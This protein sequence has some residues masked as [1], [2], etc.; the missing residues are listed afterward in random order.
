MSAGVSIPL[1]VG[2]SAVAALLLSG[3]T[4]IQALDARLV[5]HHHGMRMSLLG[6]LLGRKRWVLGTVIGYAA[7]PF[8]LIA[9]AHAPLVL[10]QPVHACGLLLLLFA[11][12][13]MFQERLHLLDLLGVAALAVGLV[14]VTWGSPRGHDPPRSEA[15]LAG[16]CAALLAA[17]IIP[18]LF[19]SRC[20]RLVLVLSAAI[21]FA[22]ANFAVKGISHDLT[23]HNY[24]VA[25]VY[26]VAAG[27]GSVVGVLSQMTAF[28]RH[29]AVDV[30][31]ITFSIPTFLPAVLGL[32][33]LH[34]R[35]GTAVAGGL[36][37]AVG[38]LVLVAG[39]VLVSRSAPVGSVSV[40]ATETPPDERP[41]GAPPPAQS[42]PAAPIP[43][44]PPPGADEEAGN[45]SPP[46]ED[47]RAEDDD[48]ITEDRRR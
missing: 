7:F 27:V 9:L 38:G 31:P 23:V 11:G 4:I 16:T 37:F 39:T 18:Y 40:H 12:A 21:G 30:V 1:G 20:S 3:G 29:R 47:P 17:A 32:L 34:Q 43:A 2:A 10:V 28:Q 24:L 6:T 33:V 41:P 8:Q 26:L 13:R 46:A 35:W 45:R 19:K 44:P 22:G 48:R 5:E 25:I 36:P 15:A 42:A 14:L